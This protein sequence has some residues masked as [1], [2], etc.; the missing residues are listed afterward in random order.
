MT[1]LF[2]ALGEGDAIFLDA[3]TLIYSVTADP[4]HGQACKLLLD[5]IEQQE[6]Q[7]YTGAHVLAEMGHRLMTVE[8]CQMFNWPAQ[9]VANRLRRHPVEVQQLVR[10]RQALD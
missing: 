1:A 10:Y 8:A 6:L 9:G 3:N 2:T 7:G 4:V 5:R